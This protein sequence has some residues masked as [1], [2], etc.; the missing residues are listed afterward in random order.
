ML[1]KNK[2]HFWR[3]LLPKNIRKIIKDSETFS[4]HSKRFFFYF[5]SVTR[6]FRCPQLRTRSRKIGIHKRKPKKFGNK[7]V[8]NPCKGISRRHK[9]FYPSIVPCR[10]NCFPTL[11]CMFS[12]FLLEVGNVFKKFRYV[13][14]YGFKQQ[15]IA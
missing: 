13:T 11:F 10:L 1:E 12:Y 4:K 9:I 7:S 8:K 14:D 2:A 15:R 6:L 5:G 3:E